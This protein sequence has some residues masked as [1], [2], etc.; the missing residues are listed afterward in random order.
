M[1]LFR[2]MVRQG[3]PLADVASKDALMMSMSPTSSYGEVKW[4]L[5]F[6]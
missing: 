2:L 4:C 5:T 3:L 1:G 6:H